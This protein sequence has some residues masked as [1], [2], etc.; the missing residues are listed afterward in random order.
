MLKS[1]YSGHMIET[2]LDEAGRGC[3]TVHEH[4]DVFGIINMNGRCYDPWLGRMLSP[5]NYV[6]AAGYSQ[7]YNRYSYALNNPLVYTDPDGEFIVIDS[8]LVGFIDG[9][10]SSGSNRFNNAWK[11]ANHRAGNDAKI[12]GGLFVSD[13]NRS[14]F[15]RVWK[16]TSRLSI[17]SKGDHSGIYNR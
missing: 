5:D 17:C 3:F 13:L 4:Y 15:G 11:G 14:F 6:Q 16:I 10:F 2:G 8:W 7:N 12:W 1:N 9:F